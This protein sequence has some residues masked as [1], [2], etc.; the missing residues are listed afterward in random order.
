[1][2]LIKK[3]LACSLLTAAIVLLLVPAAGATAQSFTVRAGQEQ[4]K[5][6]D[7]VI[8]DHVQIR[9]TVIGQSASTIDFHI[10]DPHGNVMETFGATGNVNFAF[11]CSL[12]GTYTL[13]FSNVASAENKL[14]SLDYEVT[15]Y[16]YGMP[17]MLFL[18][19]IV[20][21]ILIA[22]VAVFI[23]MSKHP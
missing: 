16:I 2:M 6:I 7:L 19:L 22:A 5:T 3:H 10:T 17:Q 12:E 14:V 4:T 1:M 21:G 8:D 15:P 13:H 9:F 20:A 23:L 11:V 18:V